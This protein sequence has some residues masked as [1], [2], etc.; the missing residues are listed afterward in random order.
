MYP[1]ERFFVFGPGAAYYGAQA[2]PVSRHI[3]QEPSNIGVPAS[4][5]R[6]P[7]TCR[8]QGR[9][10]T[11]SYFKQPFVALDKQSGATAWGYF[12]DLERFLLCRFPTRR[13]TQPDV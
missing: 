9:N 6:G 11:V 10:V 7:A 12:E 1:A 13:E 8:Q 4:S 2:L 3:N 5:T